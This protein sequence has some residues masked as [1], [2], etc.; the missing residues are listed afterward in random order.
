MSKNKSEKTQLFIS[1]TNKC[2]CKKN[3]KDTTFHVKNPLRDLNFHI[4]T[5][6]FR[7]KTIEDIVKY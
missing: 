5:L 2:T 7:Y 6:I 3:L 4:N 1:K